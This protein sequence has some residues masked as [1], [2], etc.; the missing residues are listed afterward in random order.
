MLAALL[1]TLI[2]QEV[3]IK[4]SKGESRYTTLAFGYMVNRIKNNREH[5]EQTV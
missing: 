3:E 4:I 2:T 1:K 5:Y